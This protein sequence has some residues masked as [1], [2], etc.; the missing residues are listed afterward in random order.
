MVYDLDFFSLQ[1]LQAE[2]SCRSADGKHVSDLNDNV[3][4]ALVDDASPLELNEYV[5]GKQKHVKQWK[6]EPPNRS[7]KP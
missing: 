4:T 1:C 7:P 3:T 2:T 6:G 5:Q